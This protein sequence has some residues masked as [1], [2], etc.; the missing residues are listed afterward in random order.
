M[1]ICQKKKYYHGNNKIFPP[2]FPKL[3]VYS[4]CEECGGSEDQLFKQVT[5]IEKFPQYLLI[6][7]VRFVSGVDNQ[8]WWANKITT[9]VEYP[10]DD[11]KIDQSI[12]GSKEKS[13]A[14]Y[15]LSG[16]VVSR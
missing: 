12:P 4:R 1:N 8:S 2:F 6:Q 9:P 11:L 10:I 7:L 14:V 15:S 5:N 3:I 16:V 13:S